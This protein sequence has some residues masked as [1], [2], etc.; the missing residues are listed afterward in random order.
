MTFIG[1]WLIALPLAAFFVFKLDLGVKGLWM[2]SAA[3][4]I[5]LCVVFTAKFFS[6]DWKKVIEA[7]VKRQETERLAY[8]KDMEQSEKLRTSREDDVTEY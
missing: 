5:F 2:G 6:T 3:A 7:A 8:L 4:S 1:Y